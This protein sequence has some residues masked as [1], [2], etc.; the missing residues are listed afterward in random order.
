MKFTAFA[1]LSALASTSAFAPM[2]TEGVS[3][4][5]LNVVSGKS[6]GYTS[7]TSGWDIGQVSPIVNIQGETRHT[8]NFNDA[9][10]EMTQV[11]L[12][13]TSGRPVNADIQLWVGPD[14]TPVTVKCHSEDGKEY[15]VQTMVGTRNKVANLEIM[16]T[17]PYTMPIKAAASYAIEPLA[18]ARER[19]ATEAEGRYM[20]GG[21]IYHHSFA[22]EIEQL[23]VLLK[24]EGKQLNAKIELLNGPNNVKLEYEIFTNNGNL[25]SLFIVFDT[26]KE[27]NS[28]RVKNLATMEYPCEVFFHPVKV[29]NP[30]ELTLLQW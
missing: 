22:P 6:P 4:T 7:K 28:I 18:G 14:W 15:P 29:K 17:G 21:S 27:G 19:V 3:K 8:W 16:N 13:S 20:E 12:Q 10:R 26:P 9:T 25:N 24:T 11:V 5:Q 1:F 23:S 30:A 2:S